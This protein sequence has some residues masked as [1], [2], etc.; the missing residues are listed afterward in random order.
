MEAFVY[1][2]DKFYL[3]IEN[4]NNMFS[5]AALRQR[6]VDLRVLLYDWATSETAYKYNMRQLR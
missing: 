6:L 3:R 5:E 4:F 2:F 1:N